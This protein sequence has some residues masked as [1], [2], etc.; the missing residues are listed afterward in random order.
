MAITPNDPANFTPARGN[1]KELS[2]FRF[3]CQKVLPLVY[4]DSLSYYELLNKVVNYLNMTMEDVTTL[5]DDVTNLHTAYVQLQTYVNDYFVSLDVQEE[6]DNK[7]DE[8]AESGALNELINPLLPALISDWLDEHITPTTPPVDKTLSIN[9][10]SAD[11]KMVGGNLY[12][13]VNALVNKNLENASIADNGSISSN[14]KRLLSN[15]VNAVDG[16]YLTINSGYEFRINFYRSDGTIATPYGWQTEHHFT[17]TELGYYN[18]FRITIRNSA[19]ADATIKNDEV[20]LY[21]SIKELMLYDKNIQQSVIDYI[22]EELTKIKNPLVIDN[23]FWL[24]NESIDENG[25]ITENMSRLLSAYFTFD[26]DNY[27]SITNGYEFRLCYYTSNTTVIL[28]PTWETSH[29]FTEYQKNTY[30]GARII[31]RKINDIDKVIYPDDVV[32]NTDID[33][34]VEYKLVATNEQIKFLEDVVNLKEQ[35]EY[36]LVENGINATGGT[37]TGN[38]YM[39]FEKFFPTSL[40]KN[41]TVLHAS[42]GDEKVFACYYTNSL[43][44]VERVE[45]RRGDTISDEYPLFKLSYYDRNGSDVDKYKTWIFWTNDNPIVEKFNEITFNNTLSI[46]GNSL[47]IETN[48][49]SFLF[50]KTTDASINVDTYRL[51]NGYLKT[52]NGSVNMWSNSDA[53]GVIKIVGEDDFIGGYHGDEIFS[54]INVLVDGKPIDISQTINYMKFETLDIFVESNV[55]HCNTSQLA[56]TVAFKRCKHLRF[57]GNTYSVDNT[58]TA[59]SDLRINRASLAMFQMYV[60]GN[61]VDMLTN[62]SL[63]S[64]SKLYSVSDVSVYPEANNTAKKCTYYTTEGNIDFEINV[65]DDKFVNEYNCDVSIGTLTSQDR[66]KIY[67]DTIKSGSNVLIGSGDSIYCQFTVKF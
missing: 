34:I 50:T 65:L 40:G 17:S 8:M 13:I 10:A 12:P 38:Q 3:W 64:F 6:I 57:K 44:F 63:D 59:Q 51:Y 5:E 62:Y 46:F 26:T 58:W 7:L 60:S 47:H 42:M 35:I 49:C 41:I 4:D 2:P 39:H 28:S 36:N 16:D 53:E 29:T 55:Y 15:K 45:L 24:T 22:L 21:T 11:S 33:S 31:I 19:N 66:L 27:I 1:Y 67:F 56:N 37:V 48:K 23:N 30:L 52:K 32:V 14:N 61:D 20:S 9:S 54:D 25:N 18:G 43:S